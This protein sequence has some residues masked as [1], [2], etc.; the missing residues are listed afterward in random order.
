[1]KRSRFTEDRIIG[2]LKEH[3][4][5]ISIADF[6]RRYEVS[7]AKRSKGLEDENARREAANGRASCGIP[8]DERAAGV[9]GNRLL[10]D[11]H[12]I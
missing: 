1:M 10:P 7:D 2:I 12:A 5:G 6:C 8:R 4:A 11:N 9:P 3:E